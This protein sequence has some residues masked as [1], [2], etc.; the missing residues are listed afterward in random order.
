MAPDVALLR[1]PAVPDRDLMMGNLLGVGAF[2]SVFAAR[3]VE[4][5]AVAVKRA[6]EVQALVS[7]GER[8]LSS[9]L[10]GISRTV[11]GEMLRE[12]LL[13]RRANSAHTTRLIGVCPR[14][15]GLV[16]ELCNAGSL[17][18]YLHKPGYLVRVV[19]SLTT[20]LGVALPQRGVHVGSA[21]RSGESMSVSEE[22]L[23]RS[24]RSVASSHSTERVTGNS[25][26]AATSEQV[27][28]ARVCL[29]VAQ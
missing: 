22:P 21:T 7:A 23:S 20:T 25:Q 26:F 1:R 5:A 11:F 2:G 4:G 18:D 9:T 8:D 19:P 28:S 29:F 17:F 24:K 12:A 3:H 16:L 13:L 15:F 6:E 27:R 14:P 10:R